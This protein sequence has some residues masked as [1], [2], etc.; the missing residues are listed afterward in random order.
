MEYCS[1]GDLRNFVGK[2]ID[3][4]TLIKEN[5]ISNIIKQICIGIKEIFIYLIIKLYCF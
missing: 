2:N 1:E 4:D 3:N 5:I